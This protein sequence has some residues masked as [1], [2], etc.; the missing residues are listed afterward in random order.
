MTLGASNY[1]TALFFSVLRRKPR[2][3]A[4]T[5]Q[6]NMPYVR[7]N[8][9]RELD[10][11]KGIYTRKQIPQ[12]TLTLYNN[13]DRLHLSSLRELL[14]LDMKK[15]QTIWNF[16]VLMGINGYFKKPKKRN[17]HSRPGYVA[18]Y[19]HFKELFMNPIVRS[20]TLLD[21]A[22]DFP[23]T[24][25]NSPVPF[26]VP[27][28][29]NNTVK[30][31]FTNHEKRTIPNVLWPNRVFSNAC[32]GIGVTPA[33]FKSLELNELKNEDLQY[34]MNPII[35]AKIKVYQV[36]FVPTGYDAIGL[37]PQYDNTH[38]DFFANVLK[39]P[40]SLLPTNIM[41]FDNNPYQLI[42]KSIVPIKPMKGQDFRDYDTFFRVFDNFK[43]L[44]SIRKLF[45][46]T[47]NLG[48]SPLPNLA[49]VD[50]TCPGDIARNVI[51]SGNYLTSQIV[52]EFSKYYLYYNAFVRMG[53]FISDYYSIICRHFNQNESHEPR[54]LQDTLTKKIQV[55]NPKKAYK[56]SDIDAYGS[57]IKK[58][59]NV[60]QKNVEYTSVPRNSKKQHIK[61]DMKPIPYSPIDL[62]MLDQ[63][64]KLE[65]IPMPD[66]SEEIGDIKV[67]FDK[68]ISDLQLYASLIVCTAKKNSSL[69]LNDIERA[70]FLSNQIRVLNSVFKESKW[71]KI[72]YPNVFKYIDLALP[73]DL[74]SIYILDEPKNL[75]DSPEKHQQLLDEGKMYFQI[76]EHILL[77]E[78]GIYKD[79]F[80]RCKP[81]TIK[82]KEI[83]T[84]W[85]IILELKE[86]INPENIFFIKF[87]TKFPFTIT[88]DI[89]NTKDTEKFI[90]VDRTV[91][92]EKMTVYLY[93]KSNEY[94][95]RK[96]TEVIN[97]VIERFHRRSPPNKNQFY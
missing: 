73:K 74:Q 80:V 75:K 77:L 60:N 12:D 2:D 87:C 7:S 76:M 16:R 84:N 10:K 47:R 97:D 72:F 91:I 18:H 3:L 52:R 61:V 67:Q 28:N 44:W 20:Y 35:D 14:Y 79:K 62:Y 5:F 94:V 78:H 8:T 19:R 64:N 17:K 6:N 32:R 66:T 11:R 29:Y 22:K 54:F 57:Y 26:D 70:P 46:E 51:L 85:K 88:P 90:C 58:G 34:V 82:H 31:K 15:E 13:I 33:L 55:V 86:I 71:T 81:I 37:F 59:A 96:S 24:S 53:L 83:F 21:I 41:K 69:G 65:S 27:F 42:S 89:S 36:P 25:Q 56:E 39:S 93:K 63:L 92:N 9:L 23:A 50:R 30:V 4:L 40:S 1:W 49:Y 95:P 45:Y 43:N 38:Y 48:Q 68:L